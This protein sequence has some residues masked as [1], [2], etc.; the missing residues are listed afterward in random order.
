MYLRQSRLVL[1]KEEF[2]QIFPGTICWGK[3]PAKRTEN[4]AIIS[5]KNRVLTSITWKFPRQTIRQSK[6]SLQSLCS[7]RKSRKYKPRDVTRG[8]RPK[9]KWREIMTSFFSPTT[10]PWLHHSVDFWGVHL[11]LHLLMI[12]FVNDN[13]S[14][15]SKLQHAPPGISRAFD[16]FAVPGRRE[17]D[18][19]SLPGGGEFDPHALGVGNLNWTLDFM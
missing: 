19:Q 15:K 14:V 3:R 18:Y 10:I 11:R 16:T 17:F 9:G 5:L 1:S 13:V 4:V 6:M 7:E 2:L 12:F 8:I